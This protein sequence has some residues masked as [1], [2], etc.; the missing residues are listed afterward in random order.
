MAQSRQDSAHSQ[1]ERCCRQCPILTCICRALTDIHSCNS[2]QNLPLQLSTG[3]L[4]TTSVP[5]VAIHQYRNV[6][7]QMRKLYLCNVHFLTL[8]SPVLHKTWVLPAVFGKLL[9]TRPFQH[10]LQL[11]WHLPFP[12]IIQK[13]APKG[14]APPAGHRAGTGFAVSPC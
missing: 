1:Q 14:T 3:N 4:S 9:G 8:H 12:Q 7:K 10:L 2:G 11:Y 13:S 6:Q 5:S